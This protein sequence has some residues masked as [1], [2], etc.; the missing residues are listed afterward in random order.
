MGEFIKIF[1]RKKF[2]QMDIGHPNQYLHPLVPDQTGKLG[3]EPSKIK[4]S[5]WAEC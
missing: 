2:E 5:S 1:D 4:L 3:L